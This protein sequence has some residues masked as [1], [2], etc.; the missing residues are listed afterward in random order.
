MIK[1]DWI[2]II[3]P[4]LITWSIDRVTKEWASLLEGVMSFKYLHFV[5]HHNHG[6][7]LGLFSELPAVLRIVSLST[8]GA[9]IVCLYAIIQ[10]LLPSRSLKLRAGLS[11]LL[12][13]ILGNVT[14][15]ILYGYVVDFIVLGVP[16]LASP[17]FNM[18]D[19]LQWVGYGLIVYAIIREG[20]LIWP[21]INSRKKYWINPHFQLKYSF[22]LLGVGLGLALIAGVF[23]YTYFRVTLGEISFGD[24][25]LIDKYI[26]PYLVTFSVLTITFCAMMFTVGR[27]I[28]HR[29]AGPVYAFE[30][31]M[32]D[33]LQGTE[34][35]F[36]LRES[37]EFKN[38]TVLA[39][40]IKVQLQKIRKEQTIEVVQYYDKTGSEET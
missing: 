22:I 37:D 10:Y 9:F 29:I 21:E 20:H 18:S 2:V 12:G 17:A 5:L 27:V 8:G 3:L 31:Y 16:S 35:E 25:R 36:K 23:S 11:I 28:S 30:R 7:M 1:K 19:A 6:A 13:G 34:R 15:R 33:L 40:Q 38:L 14:D 26:A 4:L 39:E 32:E 24:T